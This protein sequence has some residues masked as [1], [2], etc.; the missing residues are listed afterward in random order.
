MEAGYRRLTSGDWGIV[1]GAD[2]KA[3][4][5]VTVIK[6]SGER[7]QETVGRMVGLLNGGKVLCEIVRSGAGQRSRGGLCCCCCDYDPNLQADG[8]CHECRP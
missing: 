7:K 2:T 3:G 5:V 4:D 6:K 8:F 1:V